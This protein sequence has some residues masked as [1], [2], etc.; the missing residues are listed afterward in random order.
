MS[1]LVRLKIERGSISPDSQLKSLQQRWLSAKE[2]NTAP[3]SRYMPPMNNDG[4]FESFIRR[5]SLISMKCKYGKHKSVEYYWVLAI[6]IKYYNKWF[7][8]SDDIVAW[9][10]SSRAIEIKGRM[11]NLLMRR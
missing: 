1:K 3:P 5:D 6:F 8:S 11:L 4:S 10:R 2:I 9:D 7:V